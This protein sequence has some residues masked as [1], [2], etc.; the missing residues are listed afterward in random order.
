MEWG[1]VEAGARGRENDE[2]QEDQRREDRV[3]EQD[4]NDGVT[5]QRLFLEGVVESQQRS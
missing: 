5:L 2:R 3:E 1:V 4:R